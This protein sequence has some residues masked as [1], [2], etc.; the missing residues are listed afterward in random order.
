MLH[1][2]CAATAL[3]AGRT[4]FIIALG[5]G[6]ARPDPYAA[7]T[8][9]EGGVVGDLEVDLNGLEGLTGA[10]GRIADRGRPWRTL[11]TGLCKLIK[12]YRSR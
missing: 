6:W 9:D 12:M 1:P 2:S 7:P 10:L 4:P 3:P 5:S 8:R 11:G